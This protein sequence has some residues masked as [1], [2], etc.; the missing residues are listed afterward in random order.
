MLGADGRL[1]PLLL[2]HLQA[3]R[4]RCHLIAIPRRPRPAGVQIAVQ[5]LCNRIPSRR[6][7]PGLDPAVDRL[8]RRIQ[9]LLCDLRRTVTAP[10][11]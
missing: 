11:R 2:S 9:P 1:L 10:Q 7:V 6:L 4:Q 3:Q 5:A 8:Q